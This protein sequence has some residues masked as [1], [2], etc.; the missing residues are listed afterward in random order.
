MCQT[1]SA[2]TEF[3]EM[4]YKRACKKSSERE[5]LSHTTTSKRVREGMQRMKIFG[6]ARVIRMIDT[7]AEENQFRVCTREQEA[8]KSYNEKRDL[9]D[10]GLK[11]MIDQTR[12]NVS[13]SLFFLAQIYTQARVH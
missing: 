13:G 2:R 5:N 8:A 3:T 6:I 7:R 10:E 1:H 11:Q 12:R 9:Y 4:R